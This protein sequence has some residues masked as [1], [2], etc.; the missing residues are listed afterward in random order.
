M[1]FKVGDEPCSMIEAAS[2][3]RF[4]KRASLEISDLF[5]VDICACQMKKGNRIRCISRRTEGV[6]GVSETPW[7]I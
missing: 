3:V 7:C 4:W 2:N 6:S 1:D 5:F